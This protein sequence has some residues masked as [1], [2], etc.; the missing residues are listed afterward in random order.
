VLRSRS[1][2]IQLVG[3][4]ATTHRAVTIDIPRDSYVS[5]PGHGSDKINAAMVFGGPELTARA[6]TE[7][8]GIQPD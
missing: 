4:D 7:L 5:I 3:V 1:D 2:A 6:V 8:T